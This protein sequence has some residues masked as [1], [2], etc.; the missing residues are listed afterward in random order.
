M[1]IE[2]DGPETI[3]PLGVQESVM[4]QKAASEKGNS[5]DLQATILS[6]IGNDLREMEVVFHEQQVCSPG[7]S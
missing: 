2:Q 1:N 7:C 4:V 3:G 6:L 5:N